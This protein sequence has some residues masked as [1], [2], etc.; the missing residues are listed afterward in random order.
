MDKKIANNIFVGMMVTVGFLVFMFILFNIGG[1]GGLFSSHYR[2]F[3]RFKEVKGL[4]AG[5]E[6]SLSG[7]RAGVVKQI[8]ISAD[9]TKELIVEL[10]ILKQFRDR[11]RQ[12]SVASIKTQGVLGDKYIEISIGSPDSKELAQGEFMTTAEPEDLF[13]KG[14]DLVEGV[15]RYFDKGGDMESLL[16]NLNTVAANLAA[17]TTDLRKGKGLYYELVNG[18]SGAKVSQATGSL[19]G[20]LRKVEAGEGTLGALINDP[21]VYEDLKAMLGGAKRSNILKYFMRSFIESGSEKTS[22][23]EKKEKEK[24]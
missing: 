7:L 11:I 2:L 23:E 21:T 3:G 24:K 17:L 15:K 22:D 10:S 8:T 4:H 18:T 20:I 5:S 1:G 12:D 6:V 14:G 13:S 9:A 19:A 16:K